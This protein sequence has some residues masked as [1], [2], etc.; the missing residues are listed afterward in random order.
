MNNAGALVRI[1]CVAVHEH[2]YETAP[3]SI[4]SDA[5]D[6]EGYF[7]MTFSTSEVED[8]WK[9]MHC[10]AFLERSPMETCKFPTDINNYATGSSLLHC[11]YFSDK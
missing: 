8:D 11:P 9:L 2:G 7:F 5:T 1:R 10:K 3:F 4:L 6:D